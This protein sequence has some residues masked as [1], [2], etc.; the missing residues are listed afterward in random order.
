MHEVEADYGPDEECGGDHDRDEV[1]G[2]CDGCLSEKDKLAETVARRLMLEVDKKH[3][4]R[5]IK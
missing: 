5:W 1:D 4:K 3:C 2:S